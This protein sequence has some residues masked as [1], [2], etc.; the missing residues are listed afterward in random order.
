MSYMDIHYDPHLDKCYWCGIDFENG[1]LVY[2]YHENRLCLSCAP[3]DIRQGM[4]ALIF[5]G[6]K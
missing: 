5:D 4:T 3:T 2:P 1:D 6:R